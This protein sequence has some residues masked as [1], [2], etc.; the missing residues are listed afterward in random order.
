MWIQGLKTRNAKPLNEINFA[1]SFDGWA[2]PLLQD[3]GGACGQVFGLRTGAERNGF[4]VV[5]NAC[6]ACP[7][8]QVA[9]PDCIMRNKHRV[10]KP[11]SRRTVSCHKGETSLTKMGLLSNASCCFGHESARIALLAFCSE[12]KVSTVSEKTR[13][14]CVDAET[15]VMLF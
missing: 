5:P 6:A 12:P 15:L 4:V 10:T 8:V 7:L 9:T 3:S 14:G 11:H 2:P 13:L 1:G